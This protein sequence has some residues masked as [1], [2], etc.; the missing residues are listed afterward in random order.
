MKVTEVTTYRLMQ[1]NLD[2]IT[3]RLEDL[4]YQGATGLKLNNPS[5]D[6]ASIRPVLTTRTQI[7]HADRYLETMGVSLDEMQSTDSHLAHVEN[8][9]QRAKEIGI[10]AINEGYNTE[11]LD[12]FSR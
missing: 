6:P 11:D 9:F 2:R 10:N 7:R 12:V 5:D 8:I 1:T 3:N 4:R